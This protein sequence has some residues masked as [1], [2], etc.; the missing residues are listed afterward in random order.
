MPRDERLAQAGHR[1]R[2]VERA[3]RLPNVVV[4]RIVAGEPA[5]HVRRRRGTGEAGIE[6]NA[7]EQN[8]SRQDAGQRKMKHLRIQISD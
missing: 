1:I 3:H 4:E 2:V 8:K 7:D 5:L 6:L